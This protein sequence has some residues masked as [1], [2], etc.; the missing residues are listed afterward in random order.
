MTTVQ[1]GLRENRYRAPAAE[2]AARILLCLGEHGRPL[3]LADLARSLRSS[4]SLIF[5]VLRELE[6]REFVERVEEGLYW[7]GIQVLNTGASYVSNA[8]YAHISGV[9][10]S[11]LARDTGEETWLGIL[12]GA[13]VINLMGY[14]DGSSLATASYVGARLPASCTAQGKALLAELPD[15]DIEA[16]FHGPLPTPTSRSIASVRQ[17]LRE[18]VATRRRGYAV[19]EEETILGSASLALATALPGTGG[20]SAALSVSMSVDVFETKRESALDAL[21]VAKQRFD[22]SIG[23]VDD[24]PLLVS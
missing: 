7:L 18:C 23:Q 4:K 5:R 8:D 3:S 22:S 14:S 16:L 2:C 15:R 17:L 24:S 6:S 12:Q 20:V 19:N 13:D 9:I 1:S 21:R 11:D 10:L